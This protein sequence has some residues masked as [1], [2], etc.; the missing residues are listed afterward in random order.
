MP[1]AA[2][3]RRI[4]SEGVI[5][6]GLTGLAVA[7]PLLALLGD[8]PEFFVAGGYDGSQTR[9]FAIVVTVVPAVAAVSMVVIAD[10]VHPRVGSL[11]HRFLAGS[12]AAVT[13]SHALLASGLSSTLTV[14]AVA[15]AVGSALAF[16]L[17]RAAGLRLFLRYLA[18]GNLL[19]LGLFLFGSR[20]A[21]YISTDGVDPDVGTVE[22]QDRTS[23]VIFVLFDELPVSTLLNRE[24][25]VDE[26]RYPAFAELAKTST[27]FR[28]TAARQASTPLAVPELLTGQL[29]R[30]DALPTAASWPRNLLTLLGSSRSVHA[31]EVATDLCPEQYCQPQRSSLGQAFEDA[32]IIYAHKVLPARFTGGLPAIDRAYGGFTGDGNHGEA[33]VGGDVAA[34]DDRERTDP[35]AEWRARP[36][37][38]RAG[39][40]Q[41]AAFRE[42]IATIDDE[43]AVHLIH[44]ALPHSPWGLTPYGD[45]RNSVIPS[46][47]TP[48]DLASEVRVRLAYQMHAMQLGA[49]DALLG[50]L[51]DHLKTKG[52]FDD[53]LVVVAADHGISFTAPDIGRRRTDRNAEELLRVPLFVKEPG[54]RGGF[55]D[56]R[57]AQTIDVL[58]TII[59]V[60]G[61]EVDWE[62]DGRSLRTLRE[63]SVP[64]RVQD[65]VAPLLD[66][67]RER[68]SW[69]QPDGWRGLAA[70][71]PRGDLVGQ[72]VKDLPIGQRA[73]GTVQFDQDEEFGSLPSPGDKA[74]YVLTGKVDAP[75]KPRDVVVAVNGVVA[76]VLDGFYPS[77]GGWFFYG[78]VTDEYVDGANQVEAYVV[79]DGGV[80]R[81]LASD[82]ADLTAG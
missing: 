33:V 26:T 61:A 79:E 57:P 52:I 53:S 69:G 37:S 12:L 54:Q 13:A 9:L 40:G 34:G 18:L 81:L 56:D 82:G 7:Q 6:A 14:G 76:G 72:R 29:H 65:G 60:L 35:Y 58:P 55:V 46:R 70:V 50:E 22:L 45:V 68:A 38:E 67:A 2:R 48:G 24:G 41:R 78:L 3:L 31:L 27:W 4:A 20:T 62:L 42:V 32:A 16:G 36:L 23:P 77:D 10:L 74:P 44:V 71:G 63:P 11:V 17:P 80:L 51:T 39:S 1:Q 19:Y 5:I 64:R 47:D 30:S 21:E 59:D 66:L 43:P 15:V 28:N 49:T 25:L 8:H 73:V 75:S